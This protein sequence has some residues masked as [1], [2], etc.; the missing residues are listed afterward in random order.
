[1]TRKDY[2]L[3]AK[4]LAETNVDLYVILTFCDALQEENPSF[5]PVKFIAYVNKLNMTKT[6]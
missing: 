6:T 5:L 4:V 1:M 3:I 2:R